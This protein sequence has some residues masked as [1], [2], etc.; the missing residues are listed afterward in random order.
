MLSDESANIWLKKQIKI[1]ADSRKSR[2]KS[3]VQNEVQFVL[4]KNKQHL[5]NFLGDF[6]LLNAKSSAQKTKNTTMD[7]YSRKEIYSREIDP[8]SEFFILPGKGLEILEKHTKTPPKVN[9]DI[10]KILFQN[11][12]SPSQEK[13]QSHA[14]KRFK[15]FMKEYENNK[16][17]TIRRNSKDHFHKEQNYTNGDELEI[18]FLIKTGVEGKTIEKND[19]T[20]KNDKIDQNGKIDKNE[21]INKI[22]ERNEIRRFSLGAVKVSPN[23][24]SFSKQTLRNEDKL[25][26][27]RSV[28]QSFK[29]NFQQNSDHFENSRIGWLPL[30]P[31]KRRVKAFSLSS[32][33][34]K[35]NVNISEEREKVNKFLAENLK[36]QQTK[37][38]KKVA[39]MSMHDFKQKFLGNRYT[40][41]LQNFC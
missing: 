22:E 13:F 25:E 40:S 3:F 23:E 26:A 41:L 28:S 30:Q 19:K 4:P 1:R 31:I 17:S 21:K 15:M 39:S 38:H 37:V 10:K 8:N 9:F 14:H 24:R 2:V 32:C 27:F 35:R 12:L 7:D 5:E 11:S 18:P 36:I 33:N 6:S 16:I 20:N 34:F 29:K